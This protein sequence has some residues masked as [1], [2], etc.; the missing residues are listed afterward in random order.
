[1]I[2]PDNPKISLAAARVNADLTQAE[3]S[4]ALGVARSTLISWEAGRSVPD[5]ITARKIY[6][7]YN[8]PEDSIFFE[9]NL[10]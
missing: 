6:D 2:I 7:L 9:K 8:R 3:A 10:T 5:V 1:M 4:E